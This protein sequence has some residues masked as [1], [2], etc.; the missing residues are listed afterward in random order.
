MI[1]T[2]NHSLELKM[3]QREAE[4]NH[5][6]C[7]SCHAVKICLLKL[8]FTHTKTKEGSPCNLFCTLLLSDLPLM[9]KIGHVAWDALYLQ[10][11]SKVWIDLVKV[12]MEK[13]EKRK[14]A[15]F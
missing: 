11:E 4:N 14:K 13:E 3:N 12:W 5:I 1:Q 10:S 7:L 8:F 15:P 6:S 2:V 9:D